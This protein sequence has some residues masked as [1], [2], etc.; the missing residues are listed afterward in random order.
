[1]CK[2]NSRVNFAFKKLFGSEENKDLLIS[3][4]NAIVSEQEHFGQSTIN[5]QKA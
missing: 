2:I 3:L 1:M 5:K 4:I